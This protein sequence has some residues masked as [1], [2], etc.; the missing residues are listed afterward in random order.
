M[1]G[2]SHWLYLL[3]ITQIF[4]FHFDKNTIMARPIKDTPILN[5]DDAIRFLDKA[6]INQTNKP[7]LTER[8]RIKTNA[9]K[10]KFVQV[11]L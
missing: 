10:F 8:E 9:L 6:F 7:N 1:E 4:N 11:G 2:S 5:G 3:A